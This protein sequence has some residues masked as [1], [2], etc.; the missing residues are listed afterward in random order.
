MTK[1]INQLDSSIG[2]ILVA[3]FGILLMWI[4]FNYWGIDNTANFINV[5]YTKD[6]V[7]Y[8]PALVSGINT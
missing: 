2:I 4:I 6:R 7:F 1:V 8:L 5:D 3:V